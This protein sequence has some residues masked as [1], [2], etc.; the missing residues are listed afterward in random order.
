MDMDSDIVQDLL[1]Y[2]QD[3]KKEGV[4]TTQLGALKKRFPPL[5]KEIKKVLERAGY[6]VMHGGVVILE[7][8]P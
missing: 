4:D 3:I 1:E 7:L 6:I 8:D 2:L 5:K